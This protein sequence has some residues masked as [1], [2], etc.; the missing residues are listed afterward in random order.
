MDSGGE[1]RVGISPKT[2]QHRLEEV[3]CTWIMCTCKQALV[4]E[5]CVCHKACFCSSV[6]L[7]LVWLLQKYKFYKK[8]SGTKSCGIIWWPARPLNEPRERVCIW[9]TRDGDEFSICRRTATTATAKD[10]IDACPE[11]NLDNRT[12]M[13]WDQRCFLIDWTNPPEKSPHLENLSA[14]HVGEA[15]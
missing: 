5:V 10:K 6:V 11:E 1:F 8:K 9:K 2:K 15:R 7:G 3:T 13:T 4:R 14:C 12:W